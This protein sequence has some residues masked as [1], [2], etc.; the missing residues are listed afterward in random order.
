MKNNFTG[1]AIYSQFGF[2]IITSVL[3]GIFI[4]KKLDEIFNTSPIFLLLFIILGIVSSFLNFFFKIMKKFGYDKPLTKNKY[5][6][7]ANFIIESFTLIIICFFIGNIID[8]S[9]KSNNIFTILFILISII[10]NIFTFFKKFSFKYKLTF[11][12]KNNEHI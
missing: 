4:G 7:I 10:F 9:Y 1:Y 2:V 11:R 6:Y 12:R 8:K 3:L 5:I